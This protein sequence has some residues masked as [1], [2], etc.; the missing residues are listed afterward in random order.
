MAGVRIVHHSKGYAALLK[1]PAVRADL[2]RRAQAVA[3][4][5]GGVE[6]GYV[7]ESSTPRVRARAAV[8]AVYGDPGNKI[9]RN[10]DAGR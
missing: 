3:R 10:L 6:A 1:H 9:L 2:L 4:A 5:A 7:A 8:V